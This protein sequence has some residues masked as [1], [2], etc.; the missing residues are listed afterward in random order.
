[1]MRSPLVSRS[2]APARCAIRLA[3]AANAP[4]VSAKSCHLAKRSSS[5]SNAAESVCK[6][7]MPHKSNPSRRV[8]SAPR[9]APSSSGCRIA[10]RNN[11]SSSAVAPSSTLWRPL[12]A[13]GTPRSTR[14]LRNSDTCVFFGSNT[15]MSP[16]VTAFS[17]SVVVA[18]PSSS[19]MR[20]AQSSSAMFTSWP[21]A[22][23]GW[24]FASSALPRNRWIDNG[25]AALPLW[26]NCAFSAL[27]A[28]RMR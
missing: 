20:C 7:A 19:T 3:T 10:V 12:P 2:K 27:P 13:H 24:P 6:A 18:S 14:R 15:A 22:V 1:M 9:T 21:C 25:G 11:S 4:R 17:P 16:G 5:D 8:A 26:R 28:H 23:S